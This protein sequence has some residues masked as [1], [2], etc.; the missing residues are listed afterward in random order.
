MLMVIAAISFILVAV[1]AAR[2]LMAKVRLTERSIDEVIARRLRSSPAMAEM[3]DLRELNGVMRNLLTDMVENEGLASS[4]TDGELAPAERKRLLASRDAR[5]REI[6]AEA[7]VLLRHTR[8]VH[9]S[10]KI[11]KVAD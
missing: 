4:R 5:R 9:A 2:W 1:L 10:T 3:R 7:S 11:R 6:Y 8:P